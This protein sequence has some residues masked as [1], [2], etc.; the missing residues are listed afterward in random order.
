M[1]LRSVLLLGLCLAYWGCDDDNQPDTGGEMAGKAGVETGGEAGMGGE[2]GNGG[3]GS[4]ATGGA[5]GAA[6]GGAGGAGGEGGTGGAGGTG[7]EG[8]MLLITQCSDGEDNDDD[9]QIDLDDL[10]CADEND[11]DESDDPIPTSCFERDLIDLNAALDANGYYEGDLND[12]GQPRTQGS[13]G[14]ANGP[15]ASFI[16]ST[17]VPLTSVEFTLSTEYIEDLAERKPTVLYI[18]QRCEMIED[19]AC[20]RNSVQEPNTN[21]V[22]LQ[23]V[24]AG[25]YLVFVDTGNVTVGPGAFRLSVNTV[26]APACRDTVDNDEDGLIDLADPG[27]IGLT[28]LD[29]TDPDVIPEC[30][31]GVDNDGDRLIDYPDDP[32]CTAAGLDRERSLCLA[33]HMNLVEV[34]QSGGNFS[35][36]FDSNML[37]GFTEG[38]M[39][40]SGAESVFHITLDEPSRIRVSSD[41]STLP[42]TMYLRESCDDL[43]TQI[44]CVEDLTETLS[45]R[46]LEAGDY[47]LFVD[48]LD[49]V[50][51]F[52]TPFIDIEITSLITECNDGFDNDEDGL[53]DLFDPG[54]EADMDTS[55]Q[56]PDVTPACA[57]GIDNDEDGLIDYALE[58]GDPQCVAAGDQFERI[59]C[60]NYDVT[61]VINRSTQIFANV[62]EGT[63]LYE[64]PS[65]ENSISS[66]GIGPEVV[67]AIQLEVESSV[68]VETIAPFDTVL[69][70]RST[71]DDEE[72]QI[73]CNDDDSLQG[74]YN[75]SRIAI[76]NLAPGLYFLFADS[77]SSFINTGDVTIDIQIEPYQVP[78]T[79]CNDETDN[80]NDGLVDL[81]DPGC[82]DELSPSETNPVSL[83][84][85]GDGIDNDLDA[86]TDLADSNCYSAGDTS[87]EP[88][89]ETLPS[90]EVLVDYDA[91]VVVDINPNRF[92]S[93]EDDYSSCNPS[94]YG[95]PDILSVLIPEI[96]DLSVT[97]GD[98]RGN[99]HYRTVSIRKACDD[100]G[101]ELICNQNN[102]TSL[103]YIE[104][105][106]YYVMIERNDFFDTTPLQV[107]INVVSRVTE[108]NDEIDN[109]GNGLIDLY[110]LGCVTG[111][112]PSETLA[113]D[114]EIPECA[115]MIDNNNNDLIDYPNDPFCTGAGDVSERACIGQDFVPVPAEGI[116]GYLFDQMD[117]VD[118][119]EPSCSFSS[120]EE[121]VFG[122]TITEPSLIKTKATNSNG[123]RTYA[124]MNL[125]TDCNDE[126][127]ELYCRSTNEERIIQV[128]PG[129]YLLVVERSGQGEPLLI[130][131]QIESLVRACGDGID[132]DDDGLIDAED[133]GC[134]AA[135]DHDE[136]DD[137]T[138]A[139]SDGIDNNE[140]G[141]TDYPNDPTCV[142]AGDPT[143]YAHCDEIET[144]PVGSEGLTDYLVEPYLTDNLL[145]SSC[146]YSASGNEAV[147]AIDVPEISN[148]KVDVRNLDGSL[149][150]VY[151]ELRLSCDD[152]DSEIECF[153][154]T[155]TQR[156]FRFVEAGTYYL[157]VERSLSTLQ[158]PFN[159]TIQR[160]SLIRACNDGIDNDED[161]KTDF[162][163]DPGCEF[164][165][166]D[167]ET[168]PTI[169]PECSDGIDNDMDMFTDLEDV[170]C[171]AASSP[172]ESPVCDLVDR[173]YTI[174]Q[175]ATLQI[176]TA[177]LTDNYHGVCRIASGPDVPIMLVLTETSSIRI[178]TFSDFDTVL[179]LKSSDCDEGTEIDCND[180]GGNALNSK[181]EIDRLEP[182]TYFAFVDSLSQYSSGP[183]LVEFDIVPIIIPT[184]ECNDEIDNDDDNLIDLDDPGC[185]DE[186]SPSENNPAEIP[187]CYDGLDNDQDNTI[188]YPE[189][190]DCYAAGDH[191][192]ELRC[193]SLPSFDVTVGYEA[194]NIIRVDSQAALVEST[195]ISS[196]VGETIGRPA[197]FAFEL[198]EPSNV[199]LSANLSDGQSEYDVAISLRTACDDLDENEL[200]CRNHTD[201]SAEEMIPGLEA[202]V[203]YVVVERTNLRDSAPIDVQIRL[204]S[205]I[206]ECNDGIDNDE[207]GSIDN[208]DIGCQNG[209]DDDET[210]PEIVP[211]CSDTLD[212]DGNGFIDYPEDP[213]CVF[214][215]Q[216]EAPS[217]LNEQ[218]EL[219]TVTESQT[220]SIDTSM[221]GSDY[222][223]TCGSQAESPD[224]VVVLMIDEPTNVTIE[225]IAPFDTVLHVRR[226]ANRCDDAD[227]EIACND[228]D[229]LLGDDHDSRIIFFAEP[230]IYYIFIDGYGSMNSGTSEVIF[231]LESLITECNDEVDNDEDDLIDLAD[232]GCSSGFDV[233]EI[234]PDVATECFD[235]IDNDNNGQTDYPEDLSCIAAGQV[236]EGA[237]CTLETTDL[238]FVT[239]TTSL[240]VDTDS[241]NSDYNASCILLYGTDS[242]EKVIVLKAA[243]NSTVT[244]GTDANYVDTVLHVR[245]A[246]CDDAEAEIACNDN[247]PESGD[248]SD[249]YVSF[250]ATA[251][252]IYYIF[253]DGYG[254][255]SGLINVDITITPN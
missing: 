228:D 219:I 173:I 233:S 222:T 88:R 99:L 18:R 144:I 205:L 183:S 36:S 139:C 165:F 14:G 227:A 84:A 240:T 181:I 132:N 43:T 150:S 148:L 49:P 40:N 142:A 110:D 121:I 185:A 65:C 50:E 164:D 190:P 161:G 201:H 120:A 124:Y 87:E 26:A 236:I 137:G 82:Y 221:A 172:S 13:C 90:Y 33:P 118:L 103:S 169:L 166:D 220:I 204:V 67:I 202:G 250:A 17:S 76:R 113:A 45:I 153:S 218:S 187:Q 194:E 242:P 129:F 35:T 131:I 146:S 182:G 12:F 217:C 42:F 9:G 47:F 230:D 32:D 5:G 214:A 79:E 95:R 140:D 75:D 216:A 111:T 46:R 38:C 24:E 149:A 72:T 134:F 125:R 106:I 127:S 74:D 145:S 238:V 231:T 184:T 115:D 245:E 159:V 136:T 34:D 246:V 58:G 68:V 19:L 30:A 163:Y 44:A 157:I 156:D 178:E 206:T 191:T 119:I 243:T 154:T 151:T 91:P 20:N 160:E 108:C 28:D 229:G 71:C 198:P 29:E 133:P 2:G 249:S 241:A 66:R 208:A 255:S 80:D 39:V 224:S 59:L 15:E 16:W 22:L 54:C 92:A 41:Q 62:G 11:N 69:Y 211:E 97:V 130:D 171:F 52:E 10:G 244:V 143:E 213:F 226:G 225:T 4:A 53:T 199:Y 138:K 70:L 23:N 193:E 186:F 123:S 155:A 104:S 189:D 203:Y 73:E 147:F 126:E 192:E 235:D 168:S 170:N 195:T 93:F 239:E 56:D 253:V 234:D 98:E 252:V 188:D 1:K 83:P 77:Y 109:N 210:D 116:S 200:Y 196:C 176:N 175:S 254:S 25:F 61:Y 31:D 3:A 81:N 248:F 51:P 112:S 215:G 232:P 8:G 223:S 6:T 27:C 101:S 135:I 21:S 177:G 85:C 174:T 167:D 86:F 141:L 107:T 128:D 117:G 89:C 60:E 48:A 78:V 114:A 158:N 100:Q 212:N 152:Q 57:D 55:E 162:P 247:S 207:D 105:G 179:Y 63:D 37:N 94:P 64:S 102:T 180:D 251:D 209:F 7:G 197:I 96:S 122:L 237:F